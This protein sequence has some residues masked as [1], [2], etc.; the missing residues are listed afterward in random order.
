V[1]NA[2]YEQS[3]IWHTLYYAFTLHS[4]STAYTPLHGPMSLKCKPHHTEFCFILFIVG[5]Y[6]LKPAQLVSTHSALQ[7]AAEHKAEY[8]D[9]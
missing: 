7:L 6:I 9:R 5:I 8:N 3:A 1:T 4:K 2:F